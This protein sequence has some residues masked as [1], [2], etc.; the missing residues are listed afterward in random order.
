MGIFA[1]ALYE[2]FDRTEASLAASLVALAPVGTLAAEA[3]L[4]GVSLDAWQWTGFALVLVALL[5]L[6][7]RV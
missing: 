3:A 5:W 6:G 1:V 4:L 7:W 2:V